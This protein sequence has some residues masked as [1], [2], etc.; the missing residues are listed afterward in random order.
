M[1]AIF[2]ADGDPNC[3]DTPEMR[4]LLTQA[5]AIGDFSV[6]PGDEVELTSTMH[7]L[8]GSERSARRTWYIRDDG[9]RED[10]LPPGATAIV[11]PLPR[12]GG[13]VLRL[14]AF[15]PP[16]MMRAH[17]L[18]TLADTREECEAASDELEYRLARRQGRVALVQAVALLLWPVV[19]W[20]F[21]FGVLA[22][23]RL[24][25]KL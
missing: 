15:L 22:T 11:V 1:K 19:K 12:P 9:F 14:L 13:A 17:L 2:Y 5:V 6:K 21:I 10:S 8:D 3:L 16:G 7:F 23:V 18:Q 24:L 25:F 4:L 20:P